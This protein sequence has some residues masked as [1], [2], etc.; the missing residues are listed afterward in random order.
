MNDLERVF[1]R[2]LR[3]IYDGEHQLAGALAEL[4]KYAKSDLLKLAFR[5]HLKQTEKH[6]TRLE[7]V[8]QEIGETPDRIPCAGIEGIIDEAQ[9]AVEELLDNSALDAGLIAAGQKA[10]H[11]EISTYGTLCSWAEQLGRNQVVSLLK[12]NLE[13]EK[14]TDKAL[15]LL[16]KTYRNQIAKRHDSPRKSEEAAAFVKAIT[17]GA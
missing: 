5:H 2:E 8:F 16:A 3:E 9:T 13:D 1:V 12:E 10:E 6:A 7:K 17:H 4:E 15:T 11:Y 14:E